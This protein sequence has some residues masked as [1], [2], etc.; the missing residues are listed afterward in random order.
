ML[1]WIEDHSGSLNVLV[2]LGTLVVWLLYLQVFLFLYRRQTTPSILIS[3][4]GG[5]SLDARCCLSNMS[6]DPIHFQSLICTLK[7]TDA[8]ITSSVNDIDAL[9]EERDGAS[10]GMD[11]GPL[12]SGQVLSI[13]RFRDLV[14]RLRREAGV[15]EDKPEK[16]CLP[17]RLDLQVVAVYGADD[18]LV[19]AKRSFDI[20]LE[21]GAA[22]VRPCTADTQQVRSTRERKRLREL[23]ETYG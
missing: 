12:Q 18:L 17:S 16:D 6:S 1:Q 14:R 22:R 9:S 15:L 13:G 11:Y 5:T 7:E 19:S 23:V 20:V 4:A 21:D 3:R 8:A 2:G 10:G